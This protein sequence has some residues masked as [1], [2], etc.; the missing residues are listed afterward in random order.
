MERWLLRE[1]WLMTTSWTLT[2]CCQPSDL[3]GG[4]GLEIRGSGV[5]QDL[6]LGF[7]HCLSSG[8][9]PHLHSSSA[10]VYE[11][12]PPGFKWGAALHP[13]AVTQRSGSQLC[14]QKTHLTIIWYKLI[15]YYIIYLIKC[16]LCTPCVKR[17]LCKE[18][19][20]CVCLFCSGTCF[21][22]RFWRC[23]K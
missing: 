19:T 21:T 8:H 12:P 18:F 9:H 2:C 15:Y 13:A 5:G 11:S 20:Q 22:V 23:V 6:P 4:A 1:F 7:P 17:F 16:L 3:P 10:E 14:I